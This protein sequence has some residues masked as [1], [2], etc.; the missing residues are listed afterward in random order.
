MIEVVKTKLAGVLLIKPS[1]F[2]D[3]R[4]EYV[5][6]FNKQLYAQQGVDI[7]FVEDDV[8][9]SKKHVLRGIHGDAVTW[10]LISCLWGEFILAV[11]NCDPHS[12]EFGAWETFTLSQKNRHQVL[13]PPKY[14]NGH[15]VLSDWAIFHYKQS[16]YYDPKRQF[17]YV[18]NDPRFNIAWPIDKPILSKRD[19]T[20]HYVWS[21]K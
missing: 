1:V 10:K 3:F 12:S 17:T 16:E 14:G 15:L 7:S 5:E 13:V 11:V 4:G 20:G 18:W 19:E 9:M 21:E 2:L 6:T 8:S